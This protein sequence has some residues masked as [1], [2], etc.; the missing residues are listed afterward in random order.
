MEELQRVDIKL[1]KETLRVAGIEAAKLRISRR[2]YL[3][4]IIEDFLSIVNPLRIEDIP[5]YIYEVYDF[6]KTKPE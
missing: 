6:S 4:N 1:K 5:Q 2:Q 3:A